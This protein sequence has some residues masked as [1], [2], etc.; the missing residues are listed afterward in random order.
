[1]SP[2]LQR[3][4]RVKW[5]SAVLDPES[6]LTALARLCGCAIAE[7]YNDR[8]GRCDPSAA[9]LAERM[10]CCERT[11]Q[12]ARRHLEDAGFLTVIRP[13]G[14]SAQ[15]ALSFPSPDKS[16]GVPLTEPLTQMQR[17]PDTTSD[18]AAAE[19]ENQELENQALRRRQQVADSPPPP[20]YY[21][22]LERLNVT[23]RGVDA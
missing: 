8:T 12:R 19:P 14:A 18:R 7:H 22:L 4:L 16:A 17:T 21:E 20:E 1:M 9:T 6:Q 15:L 10:G 13:R 23:V 5:R 11:A 2:S 3:P